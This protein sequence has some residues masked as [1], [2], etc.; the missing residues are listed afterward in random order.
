[1]SAAPPDGRWIAVGFVLFRRFDIL[2]PWPIQ[3]ADQRVGGGFGIL[4]DDLL[5]AVYTWIV[6]Q[7]L[8]YC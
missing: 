8:A 3:Q 6:L 5:A 2:K 7:S 1:M 4:F